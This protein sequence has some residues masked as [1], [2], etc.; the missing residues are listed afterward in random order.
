LLSTQHALQTQEE[1]KRLA[2]PGLLLVDG[3][4]EEISVEHYYLT[5]GATD[6]PGL[7][8]TAGS[9]L[10]GSRVLGQVL[11]CSRPASSILSSPAT[12]TAELLQ[13]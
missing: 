7:Q 8:I 3:K 5:D 2:G 6:G 12:E 4:F 11:F 13:L 9:E 10:N 1:R